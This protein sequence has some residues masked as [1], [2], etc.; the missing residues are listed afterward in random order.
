M[1]KVSSIFVKVGLEGVVWKVLCARVCA[2]ARVCVR[3]RVF[4]WLALFCSIC[5]CGVNYHLYS[6]KIEAVVMFLY[7]QIPFFLSA[8]ASVLSTKVQSEL[9]LTLF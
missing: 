4:G 1:G 6:T 5:V 8:A 7:C 2:L 3:L 9:F